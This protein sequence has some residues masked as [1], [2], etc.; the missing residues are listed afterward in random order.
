MKVYIVLGVNN[1]NDQSWINAVCDTKETATARK[2]RFDNMPKP[3]GQNWS[4][5]IHER[6]MLTIS[7]IED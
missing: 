6:T 4:Y 2:E 3:D 5:E 1:D 7:D